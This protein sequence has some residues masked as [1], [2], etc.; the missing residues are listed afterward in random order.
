APP[1]LCLHDALP[2]YRP[3]GDRAAT[4]ARFEHLLR[5]LRRARR[6]KSEAAPEVAELGRAVVEMPCTGCPVVERCLAT[7]KDLR[8]VE[9]KRRRLEGEVAH[10][11]DQEVQVF[12]RRAGILRELGYL[13]GDF[14]LTP[15]GRLAA[16]IRHPRMLILA[17]AIR[18]RILPPIHRRSPQWPAP[19][20]PSASGRR[21]GPEWRAGVDFAPGTDQGCA[22]TTCGTAGDT[23]SNQRTAGGQNPRREQP[24]IRSARRSSA[25]AAS[26]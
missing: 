17:E 8:V 25:C 2:I 18:L 13:D 3:C 24:S 22:I 7:I 12:R 23:R 19:S 1:T 6:K 5:R 15:R 26:S 21:R 4:R 16:R 20:A 14:R 11:E 10:L 9:R